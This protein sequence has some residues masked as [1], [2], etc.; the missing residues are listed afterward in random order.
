MWNDSKPLIRKIV[1]NQMS[2]STSAETALKNI[3]TFGDS[4]T[5]VTIVNSIV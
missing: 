4:S 3:N 5:T 2:Y 1:P